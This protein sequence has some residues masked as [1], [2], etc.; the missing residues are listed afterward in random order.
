MQPNAN[1]PVLSEASGRSKRSHHQQTPEA[2]TAA[3]GMSYWSIGVKSLEDDRHCG[4]HYNHLCLQ[5]PSPMACPVPRMNA[6]LAAH[7][8]VAV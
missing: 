3:C 7:G 4:M 6:T 8:T 2:A 5:T 1:H